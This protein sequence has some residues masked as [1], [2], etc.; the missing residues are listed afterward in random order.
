MKPRVVTIDGNKGILIPAS[1]LRKARLQG[2]VE[3]HVRDDSLVIRPLGNPREGWDEEFQ[4]MAENGDDVLLDDIASI[5]NDF[6]EEE[7]EW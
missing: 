5:S 2:D 4:K 3:V 1:L 6:D 7:W